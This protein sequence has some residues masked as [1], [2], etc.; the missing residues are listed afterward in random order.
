MNL[1]KKL[2]DFSVSLVLIALQV[3]NL[4]TTSFGAA[5]P[6]TL[7]TTAL[8]GRQIWPVYWQEMGNPVWAAQVKLKYYGSLSE[9]VA[10]MFMDIYLW[11]CCRATSHNEDLT[12]HKSK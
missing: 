11:A 8:K 5:I 3:I 1:F 10:E 6:Y 4:N 12:T 9:P 2:N 7:V